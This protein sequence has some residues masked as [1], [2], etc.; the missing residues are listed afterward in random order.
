MKKLIILIYMLFIP[1]NVFSLSADS[2]VV[3][4]M[5]TGRI[6]EEKNKDKK[7]LVASTSKIMTT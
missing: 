1:I 5:D 3:M 4:D 7:M 2:F 6:L